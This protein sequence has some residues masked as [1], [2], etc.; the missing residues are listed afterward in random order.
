MTLREEGFIWTHKFEGLQSIMAAGG[1]TVAGM[2][3]WD[4]RLRSWRDKKQSGRPLRTSFQWDP[5]TLAPC[6]PSH[7]S[8]AQLLAQK[9]CAPGQQVHSGACIYLIG[10]GAAFCAYLPSLHCSSRLWE[11][12]NTHQNPGDCQQMLS[13]SVSELQGSSKW[14]SDHCPFSGA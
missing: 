8:S 12:E 1:S 9:P 4:P 14:E 3:S 10:H 2:C 5:A 6:S 11:G 13:S 7:C